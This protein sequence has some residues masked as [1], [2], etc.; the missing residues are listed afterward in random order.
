MTYTY[1]LKSVNY[2]K[3]YVGCTTD[4]ERRLREHNSGESTFTKRF[5]PWEL[6]YKEEF[7]NISDARKR[8]KYFK[9]SSGRKKIKEIIENLSG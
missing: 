9:S 2:S 1:I 7:V 4:L 5:K 6:I 3:T 8:E